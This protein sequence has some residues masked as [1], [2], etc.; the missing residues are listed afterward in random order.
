MVKIAITTNT[1]GSYDRQDHCVNVLKRFHQS[2]PLMKPFLLQYPEDEVPYT[3]IEIVRNLKRSSMDLF[4]NGD[5]KFPFVNDLFEISSQLDTEYFVY[6][7]S[8][9]LITKEFLDHIITMAP[10]ALAM[11]RVDCK[12]INVK[13]NNVFD[14]SPM[15]LEAAGFDAFIFNNNWWKTNKEKFH[16]MFL[17]RPV[18]DNCYAIVMMMNS[19]N[20][21]DNRSRM[22]YHPYHKT[23][24]FR[25]DDYYKFNHAQKDKFYKKEMGFWDRI[26]KKTFGKRDP[27]SM[28]N[29][30]PDEIINL[31]NFKTDYNNV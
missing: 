7:N 24:S 29:V 18:F 21:L 19:K 15:R 3:D 8:D 14:I 27:K 25:N 5:K 17:G 11:S 23:I 20:I 26:Y 31:H 28:L 22:L 10:E 13:D 12:I 30:L 4:P 2:Y 9:I 6:I 1:F 16:D